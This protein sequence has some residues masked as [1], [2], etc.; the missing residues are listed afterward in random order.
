M[1]RK[2]RNNRKRKRTTK[3]KATPSSGPTVE[4]DRPDSTT[5]MRFALVPGFSHLDL[6]SLIPRT[7]DGGLGVYQVTMIL[8]IP[9]KATY[10]DSISLAHLAQSGE[11][12]LQIGRFEYDMTLTSGEVV[13]IA[14]FASNSAG[15]L[16]TVR[17]RIEAQNFQEA[18]RFAYD[19][20]APCLSWCSYRYDVPL[21]IKGYEVVEESTG[22]QQYTVGMLGKA[23]DFDREEFFTFGE[24]FRAI[25][26]IYREAVN[27]TNLFYK[28]LSFYKVTEGVRSLLVE[29]RQKALQRNEAW[30]DPTELIPDNLDYIQTDRWDKEAFKPFL[31]K[32]FN[33]VL[34]HL[35]AL[36]RN[37]VAH[38]DPASRVLDADKFADLGACED[39]IPILKY[40]ARKMLDRELQVRKSDSQDRVGETPTD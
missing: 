35:R 32:K 36:I 17:I 13:G 8:C 4:M 12:L 37:A 20:V 40:I 9:G 10:H 5:W 14:T 1:K 11:S 38:L 34:N 25:L 33:W 24:E 23:K 15:L 16:S 22:T 29:R 7:P 2:G 39:A 30:S 6:R 26:A 3:P 27:S 21:D 31:G 28:V 19:M 18:R